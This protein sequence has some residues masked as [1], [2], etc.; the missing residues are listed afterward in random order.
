MFLTI[1]KDGLSPAE[2]G[3]MCLI[4]GG[5]STLLQES[6][7]CQSNR[8]SKREKIVEKRKLAKFLVFADAL[9]E[10]SGNKVVQTL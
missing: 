2:K 1:R 8:V 3:L 6:E 9:Q 10:I 4:K 5:T 7:F